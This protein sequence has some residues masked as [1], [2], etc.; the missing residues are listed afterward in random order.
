[1]ESHLVLNADNRREKKVEERDTEKH[2]LGCYCF[3]IFLK[4]T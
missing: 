1:M 2:S 3:R 4:F